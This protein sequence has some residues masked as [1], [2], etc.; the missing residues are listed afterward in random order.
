ML[1][2]KPKVSSIDI[3]FG[4][5]LFAGVQL[6]LASNPKTSR[7]K[8]TRCKRECSFVLMFGYLSIFSGIEISIFRGCAS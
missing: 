3:I 4:V 2:T 6:V 8:F 7:Y 1:C 5:Q